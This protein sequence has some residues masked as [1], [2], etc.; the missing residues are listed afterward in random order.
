M[1]AELFNRQT[2]VKM[3]P[4][5]VQ[6]N[7]QAIV[8]VIGG[9]GRDDVRPVSTSTPHIKGGKL[10][11]LAVT[12]LARSPL[13][14]KCRPW[15]KPGCRATRNI[16]STAS[17]RPRERLA[18][19]PPRQP[20]V[21]RRVRAPDLYKRFIERAS[22]SGRAVARGVQRAHQA[23]SEKKGPARAR[24]RNQ[25]GVA[26]RCSK[27]TQLGIAVVGSGR[28][29]S[30]RAQLAPAP[31]STSSPSPMPIR[32]ARKSSR[33]RPPPARNFHSGDNLGGRSRRPEVSA[34][35]V[36]MS[37]GEQLLPV[38]QALELGKA[39]LVEKPLALTLAEADAILAAAE[40]AARACASATAGA[41]RPL[42]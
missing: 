39:V 6:G 36:A 2:G 30:L 19:S 16:S 27:R 34:V 37:E 11:A 13:L 38:M 15:T 23:R 8:D 41:T 14:P 17:S 31:A 42:P 3:L 28:I 5:P 25:V 29:G 35:V 10:R 20:A 33:G 40:K 4:R 32:R 21:A 12:S 7:S 24:S 9:Q 1:A 22:S 18:R 26:A